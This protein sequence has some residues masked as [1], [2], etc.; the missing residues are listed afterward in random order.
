MSLLLS[1][2][3]NAGGEDINEGMEN[4]VEVGDRHENDNEIT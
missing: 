4:K 3:L 2:L 1:N